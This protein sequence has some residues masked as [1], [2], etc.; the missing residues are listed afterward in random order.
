MIFDF[1][2]NFTKNIFVISRNAKQCL[3]FVAVLNCCVFHGFILMS[4]LHYFISLYWISV[5][6]LGRL[7]FCFSF[8]LTPHSSF[9]KT[10]LTK[11]ITRCTN[12]CRIC[13]PSN[14]R[15]TCG[16]VNLNANHKVLW[17]VFFCRPIYVYFSAIFFADFNI[18][19]LSK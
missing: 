15:S 17:M 16:N 19:F 7:Y 14:F 11:R 18:A 8:V 4:I 5:E 13:Q 12:I 9:V 10:C 1:N 2:I 6:I 3:L